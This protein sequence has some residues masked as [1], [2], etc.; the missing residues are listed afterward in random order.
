MQSTKI[1]GIDMTYFILFFIFSTGDP[2]IPFKYEAR[3]AFKTE[4]ECKKSER[5]MNDF[6]DLIFKEIPESVVVARCKPVKYE[7]GKSRV[8]EALKFRMVPAPAYD[9]NLKDF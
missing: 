2:T 9:P 8:A 3:Q 4:A 5:I 6:G 1:G 7:A